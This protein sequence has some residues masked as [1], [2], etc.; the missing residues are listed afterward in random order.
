[1]PLQT[2]RLAYHSLIATSILV[3]LF[4]FEAIA[5]REFFKAD[6]YHFLSEVSSANF[7]WWN[8]FWPVDTQRYF[9][10]RPIGETA[11]FRLAY[12][13]FGL[14]AFWY[15]QLSLA[16]QLATGWLAFRIARQL[17]LNRAIATAVGLAAASR[18]A[19]MNIIW[20]G[21][22]FSYLLAAFLAAL[23]VT[24]FIDS[25]RSQSRLT[26]G[27][28]VLAYAL[29]L[30]SHE[31]C[32]ALPLV[33]IGFSLMEEARTGARKRIGAAVKATPHLLL[34]AVF[35]VY[36]FVI[37]APISSE[38][39]AY[40]FS[41]SPFH[42]LLRLYRQVDYM[43]E[44]R[45]LLLFGVI[46]VILISACLVLRRSGQR[47]FINWFLLPRLAILLGWAL[48]MI[49]PTLPLTG[50]IAGRYSVHME[51]PACLML[52]VIAQGVWQASAVHRRSLVEVAFMLLVLLSAP[53]HTLLQMYDED[54]EDFPKRFIRFA[55]QQAP[56]LPENARIVL[57]HGGP[58]LAS[59]AEMHRFHWT[60]YGGRP[61]VRTALPELDVRYGLVDLKET[62]RPL[63]LRPEARYFL[64]Q[65]GLS[66]RVPED[67]YILEHLIRPN[68]D[69]E[70]PR[71]FQAAARRLVDMQGMKAIPLLRRS[72]Q[73]HQ[74]QVEERR[75][76]QKLARHFRQQ[77]HPQTGELV[78][79]LLR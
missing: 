1:M 35:A 43:V 60:T 55:R 74:N 48:L 79:A 8:T 41:F 9:A 47:E 19:S 70:N 7:S 25:M 46:S 40:P 21:V 67:S 57:L 58:G 17:E 68:L 6:D 52:G 14:E 63:Y 13:S 65:E 32:F 44:G 33:L 77:K 31:A 16:V 29:S 36:R 45:L 73:S 61:L 53:W 18:L 78:P 75:C 26:L 39:E 42:L 50:M 10:F 28:S 23:S 2:A 22:G 3:F 34:M 12:Q 20:Y 5:W 30:L 24:L 49:G 71:L 51:V 72:C 69:P 15:Y 59:P 62:P 38:S 56:D 4:L 27:F 11:F 66:F 64:I 76:L 37:V 54:P